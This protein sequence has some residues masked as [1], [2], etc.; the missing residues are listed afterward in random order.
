MTILYITPPWLEEQTRVVVEGEHEEAITTVIVGALLA[1]RF[2][3]MIEDED[4]EQVPYL[5]YDHG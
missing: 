2:D 4:G 1:G 5:E 3:V